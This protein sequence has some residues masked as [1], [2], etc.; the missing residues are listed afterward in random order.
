VSCS[1]RPRAKLDWVAVIAMDWSVA[2]V[3]VSEA[4]C[5]MLLRVAVRVE[6]PT[7]RELMR[8]WC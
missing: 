8:P 3:A 4:T 6:E 1:E 5:E 7:V 2:E